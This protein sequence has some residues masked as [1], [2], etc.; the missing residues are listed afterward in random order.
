MELLRRRA[1]RVLVLDPEDRL[2]LLRGGDPAVPGPRFW[3]T[4]GGGLEPGESV[5][6]GAVRELHEET[7]LVVPEGV[8]TGPLHRDVSSFAFDRWWVEQENEFFAVRVEA[9]TPS[10]A[11]LEA[12]EVASIDGS[13]WWTLQQLRAHA[14]GRPHDGPGRPG[15]PVYPLDLPD[16]LASALAAT[17]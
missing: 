17:H 12:T 7:G 11:A 16:V 1:A 5:R 10:P 6:A 4:V 14:A 15:E 2:L 8:L 13:G 9:W 3:W